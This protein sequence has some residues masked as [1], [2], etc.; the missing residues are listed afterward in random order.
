MISQQLDNYMQNLEREFK[1]IPEER[2]SVLE[3]ISQFIKNQE[4][5]GKN[6]NLN[7]ICTHN[8]RRSHISQIWAQA[9]AYYYDVH[10]VRSYSGGT[11]VT[12]FNPRAVEGIKRAGFKIET[13]KEGE[14]PLYHVIFAEDGV[15]VE[16]FS[17]VFDDSFNPTVDMCAVMVCNHADQNC[18]FVTGASA[19]ILLPF[20]DPKEGDD[21]PNESQIYDERIKDMGIEIMYL[22]SKVN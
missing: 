20:N 4:S 1:L 18:P 10:N 15:I 12:A 5:Q 11:E 7:F 8:S 19:R 14:N 2:K 17:K 13:I 9:A 3:Q 22:M 6:A 21:T 16:A